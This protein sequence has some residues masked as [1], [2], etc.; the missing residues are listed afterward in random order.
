M[1]LD[2]SV[3]KK[4]KGFYL[5]SSFV[6]E[7]KKSGVFGPSG[8]GKSTLAKIIAGLTSPDQGRIVLNQE[9]LFDQEKNINIKPEK[10]RIGIVFQH[11]H[12]FPHLNV[13]K[14][15]LYGWKRT[16]AAYRK[17]DPE[18]VV[19]ALNLRP[20]LARK[21]HFLSGGERQRVAL[22]R[23]MLASPRLI[24]MDEPLTGLDKTMKHR[25]IDYM[26]KVLTDFEIPFIYISHSIWE[27]ELMTDE[28]LVFTSNSQQKQC[29][30]ATLASSLLNTQSYMLP[31]S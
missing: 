13:E 2:V 7:K 25:V 23:T 5:E 1:N 24:L 28:V 30:T 10:R 19:S 29:S 4:F 6:M 16:Q 12:L 22:G 18:A 27:M 17:I 15:L 9:V 31:P 26:K 21:T 3:K 8:S 14:N 11:A 20:L